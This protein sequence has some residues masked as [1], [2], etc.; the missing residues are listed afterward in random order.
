MEDFINYFYNT[1]NMLMNSDYKVKP[2]VIYGDSVTPDTPIILLKKSSNNVEIRYIKD[3]GFDWKDYNQFKSDEIGLSEKQHDS[4]ITQYYK[5]WTDKGWSNIN[6]VIRH[7]TNKKIYEIITSQAYVKVTSDHSLLDHNKNQI[8]P[9]ECVVGTR[10]LHN[11]EFEGFK[12]L[13]DEDPK[14][15]IEYIIDKYGYNPDSHGSINFDFRYDDLIMA[16]RMY[17]ACRTLG[18]YVQIRFDK[19]NNNYKRIIITSS[20]I[21][22]ENYDDFDKILEINDL[23]F[24]D[25]YVYDLE[26]DV[27]HFHAGVGSLIVK[28]TDSVFF[29]PKIHNIKTK[30]IKTDRIALK[31]CIE[32]GKLAGD[33]ICKILPEPEEQVYEKT[34]WPFIILSKKHYVGNL[35]EDDDSYFKQKSMGI[36][37]KRRDNA[38]IVKIVVGGIVDY[39]LN[40][41]PGETNIEDRNKGAI[42][43][44]RTLLKKILR[45]E[46]P[47]D[48]YIVSKTL[49]SNYADRTRI[50]HAVL[51]D[52][53]GQRDPGNKPESN[54]RVPYVY[55][56]SKGKVNL[57]GDRVEDPKY[58]L[59]NNLELDY[60]FYITNQIMKPAKQFL[61]H[62]ANNPDKLF[63]N[64]INKEINRR[65]K[66][67]SVLDYVSEYKLDSKKSNNDYD[68]DHS[69][70]S[71]SDLDLISESDSESE[72]KLDKEELEN[73]NKKSKLKINLD[74][75]K[76]NK[77]IT[78]I[79]KDN[80][81][82]S[83]DRLINKIK[84]NNVK[85]SLTISF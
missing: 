13:Y 62:I 42:E 76:N 74:K 51:A 34:L 72:L 9:S 56:I 28:N 24:I 3:I 14:E 33:T 22:P 71:D 41:K 27:G 45:G 73:L 50:V 57:Q 46:Y 75:I 29:T 84:L 39:I 67:N 52:R 61:E 83:E 4:S 38:K 79:D 65:K 12:K 15:F 11:R 63:E 36:V 85:K 53:I 81:S 82:D 54:D 44:T 31:I 59:A 30:Q 26:T 19:F 60:L 77:S 20:K 78:N 43:Y 25:D 37:L 23:G 8:K 40:G 35:Y 21:R 1:I 2:K 47:I 48:K 68:Y 17:Y 16:L 10:L 70:N 18:Y 64:Y 6:R 58:V 80:N 69:E 5:V 32:I 55:I 7:K 49:R 66:I